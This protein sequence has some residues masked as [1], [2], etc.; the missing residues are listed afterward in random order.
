MS[1]LKKD[2]TIYGR[3]N[4]D[5][6]LTTTMGNLKVNEAKETIIY[7]VKNNE[8]E[9]SNLYDFVMESVDETT[10]P[11]GVEPRL[12][13]EEIKQISYISNVDNTKISEYDYELLDN[14]K[15]INFDYFGEEIL[16]YRIY[17]WGCTGNKKT[18]VGV[19]FET[20][21]E[22]EDY[23]FNRVYDYD[24]QGDCNRSTYYHNSEGDA[25]NEVL[26]NYCDEFD[27]SLETANSIYFK[28]QKINARRIELE[29]LRKS[30]FLNSKE[31]SKEDMISFINENKDLIE[32][33]KKELAD[34]KASDDKENWQIKA[35]ALVQ[36]VSK[37]DFR[38]LKW[39]EIYTL[40][41]SQ[42]LYE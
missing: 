28:Q 8:V 2:I 34:L 20:E 27:I 35:N 30:N 26:E 29:E 25:I 42:N 22:A 24:F 23:L 7:F 19:S 6:W 16:E 15:T 21:E 31:R 3:G 32:L 18:S 39:K 4:R 13:Y 10:S 17:S 11:R 9:E 14:E 33:K 37:N 12:F 36:I 38:C 1:I 5:K 40:I 41:N